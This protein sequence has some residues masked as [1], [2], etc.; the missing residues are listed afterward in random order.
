MKLPR[1]TFLHLAAGSAA[2][3][4][5]SPVAVLGEGTIT[6]T[7]AVRIVER[8]QYYAK[9][10]LAAEVLDIRR[11]ASDVRVSIGLLAGEILLPIG[12]FDHLIGAG[13]DA[14]RCGRTA[15]RRRSRISMT[16]GSRA[17]AMMP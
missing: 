8:T 10:G 4:I 2:L 14:F 12:I 9:A 16:R 3:P 7:G 15:L 13:R 5:A 11:K 17:A 6:P 1:R